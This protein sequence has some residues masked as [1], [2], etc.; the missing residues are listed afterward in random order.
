MIRGDREGMF[1]E[2]ES[3]GYLKVIF[4]SIIERTERRM[5]QHTS[6]MSNSSVAE[7]YLTHSV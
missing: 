6:A 5:A 2:R 3:G 7:R 4:S 1:R